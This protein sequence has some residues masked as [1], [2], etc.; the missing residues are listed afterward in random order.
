MTIND[1][2][3]AGMTIEGRVCIRAWDDDADVY[4]TDV[5]KGDF[6]QMHTWDDIWLDT[7]IEYM[8]AEN[9]TLIIEIENN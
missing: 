8:F 3:E 4:N 5:D 6:D 7:P 9:D 1:M 2:L